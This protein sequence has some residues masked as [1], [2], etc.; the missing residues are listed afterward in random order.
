V[1][2]LLTEEESKGIE[3]STVRGEEGEMA[4]EVLTKSEDHRTDGRGAM[5]VLYS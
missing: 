4:V 2:V 3:W 5:E 1:R